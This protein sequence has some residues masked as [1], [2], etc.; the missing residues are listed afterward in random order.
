MD[1]LLTGAEKTFYFPAYE[2][3]MTFIQKLKIGVVPGT[4]IQ[5]RVRGGGALLQEQ[6]KS[7]N[8]DLF[9]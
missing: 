9:C 8:F 1:I 6:G 2:G 7:I 3:A 4:K 5:E